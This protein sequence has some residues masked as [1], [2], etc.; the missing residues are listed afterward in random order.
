MIDLTSASADLLASLRED[1]IWDDESS[2]YGELAM[3]E[4]DLSAAQRGNFTDLKTKGLITFSN[5]DSDG[6][7]SYDWY[8]IDMVTE[9]LPRS[10]GPDGMTDGERALNQEEA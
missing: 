9:I 10:I 4:G 6:Y 8:K 7:R 1:A 2:D 5:S 3:F